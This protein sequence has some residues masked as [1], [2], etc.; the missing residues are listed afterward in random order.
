MK[1]E[2]MMIRNPSC[3]TP[4]D[5]VQVAASIMKRF[6]TG[7]VP[8]TEQL[9]H[10]SRLVGVITDRDLC[11]GALASERD[12]ATLR[13]EELMSTRLATCLPTDSPEKALDQMAGAQVRRLPV[14][15]ND[16]ELVGILSLG[17]IV[18][19]KAATHAQIYKTM[20]AI[21]APGKAAGRAKKIAA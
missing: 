2:Q 20:A 12:P 13:V 15:N 11:L 9:E 8:V 4:Q 6:D 1:V 7:I 17:D 18:R 3:C 21:W 16:F 5:F 14:V 10:P 19:H